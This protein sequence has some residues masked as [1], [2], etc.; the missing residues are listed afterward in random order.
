MDYKELATEFLDM[1]A[2]AP[3]IKIQKN[4]SEMA[5]GEHSTL[6][7]LYSCGNHAHPK[8][9]SNAMM[10]T[11]ARVASILKSLEK[12]GMITREPDPQD[13][14]QI[15]VRLTEKGFADIQEH[16]RQVIESTAKIF[17]YLGEEDAKSYVRIQKKLMEFDMAWR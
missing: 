8:D 12:Q 16:R 7:Y 10:V 17:E 14:R 11:T 5:R 4:M 2:R 15:I 13:S 6:N 1:Q 3:Q 9:I